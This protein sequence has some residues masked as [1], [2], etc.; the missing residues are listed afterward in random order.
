[1][2]KLVLLLS[3][4]KVFHFFSLVDLL[5]K[6]EVRRVQKPYSLNPVNGIDPFRYRR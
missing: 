4:F 2:L 3:S 6:K 5:V 1:L